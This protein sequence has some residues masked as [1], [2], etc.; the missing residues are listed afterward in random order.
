MPEAVRPSRGGPTE[1][2]TTNTPVLL[3]RTQGQRASWDRT[4]R[5]P[6][7]PAPPPT[8]PARTLAHLNRSGVRK[9]RRWNSS[10]RLF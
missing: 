3:L 1:V 7:I 9:L 2:G 5:S 8:S 10:S 6:A 4:L